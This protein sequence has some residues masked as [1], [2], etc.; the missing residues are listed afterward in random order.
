MPRRGCWPQTRSRVHAWLLCERSTDTSDPVTARSK[1]VWRHS[2]CFAS[3]CHVM[4]NPFILV[5][6]DG[7]DCPCQIPHKHGGTQCRAISS[8]AA[9]KTA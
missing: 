7:P 8:S 9:A 5:I 4:R 2:V 6:E 3:L 1:I